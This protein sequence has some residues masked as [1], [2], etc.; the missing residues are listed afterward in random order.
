M[1]NENSIPSNI[2]RWIDV[3]VCGMIIRLIN[4][5][6]DVNVVREA[7]AH[8]SRYK[9]TLSTVVWNYKKMFIFSTFLQ[10]IGNEN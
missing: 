6:V 7:H 5:S 1:K 9:T 3:I 8:C 4:Q 10:V 2:R